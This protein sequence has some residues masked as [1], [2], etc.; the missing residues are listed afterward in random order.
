MTRW[1]KLLFSHYYFFPSQKLPC[2]TRTRN[3]SSLQP[4]C[5]ECTA[6]R[7][8]KRKALKS[9]IFASDLKHLLVGGTSAHSQHQSLKKNSCHLLLWKK[10]ARSTPCSSQWPNPEA[11]PQAVVVKWIQQNWKKQWP[12]VFVSFSCSWTAFLFLAV[13]FAP[14]GSTQPL[15]KTDIPSNRSKELTSVH[16]FQKL[17]V[18][19]DC[20]P[21]KMLLGMQYGALYSHV[22]QTAALNKHH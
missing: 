5:E 20:K 8:T 19:W 14:L 11:Q 1:G 17:K 13:N 2:Q 18:Y 22:Y 4:L 12:Q 9:Y 3:V 15:C 7:K 16:V 10:Q 6:K 21:F